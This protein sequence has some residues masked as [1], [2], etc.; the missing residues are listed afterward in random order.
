MVLTVC[1]DG[2]RVFF[3]PLLAAREANTEAK[4]K[5]QKKQSWSKTKLKTGKWK[6]VFGFNGM[7]WPKTDPTRIPFKKSANQLKVLKAVLEIWQGEIPQ[8]KNTYTYICMYKSWK[9]AYAIAGKAVR[10]DRGLMEAGQGITQL[11]LEYI[12][13]IRQNRR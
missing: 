11:I 3:S 9:T 4:Q 10:W 2:Q 12:T 5:L 8:V 7:H 13:S 1:Q 6:G